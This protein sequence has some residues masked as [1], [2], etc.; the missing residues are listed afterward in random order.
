MDMN[1]EYKIPA[2]R[3]TVWKALNDPEV[4][5]Q[6]IPGCDELTKLG[7]DELEA[8]VTSKIGPVKAKFA[9]RVR[10]ENINAPVSYTIVGEGKG[11]AAGFAK[12]GADVSLEEIPDGTLLRYTA[13]AEVGGKLAQIGSRLIAGAS[14][15]MAD[16]FFGKFSEIVAT[17][18]PA[19]EPAAAA[20][21]SAAPPPSAI[22]I[23]PQVD[24]GI[25]PAAADFQGGVLRCQCERDPVVVSIGAQTAFN[26][27]CGCSKCWKPEG[28]LFSQIAVVG[29]DNLAVNAG[30]H[31]LA[32]VDP[33][34]AI[35]RHAC[36]D[37]GVHMYGRIENRDHPFHGFDF[38]HTELSDQSGWSPAEFA[39][40]VSSI[41]ETGTDPGE[42]D[43]I[44][45]RLVEL[46]LEPYDCLAPGLMDAIAAHTAKQ[47]G[48]VAV[49]PPR[50]ADG[51]IAI[52]PEVDG[53]IAAT[54]P[55]LTGGTLVCKCT[56]RP[57][58]VTISAQTAFNHVCGCSKCWKPDGALFSQVAVVGRD[59]LHVTANADK[60]A[61]VDS[62]AAIQRHACGDCGAH[63]YGRIENQDHPFH[64]FDFV[65]TELGRE[66]GWAAPEFAAFVSSIIETGT[67]PEAMDEV[68]GRRNE[69]GLKPHDVLTPQLMDLIA[70]H[71]AKRAAAAKSAPAP[72]PVAAAA[73]V[74]PPPS[75]IKIHPQVDHGI[76]PAVDDFS[77]G[78]LRCQC[79]SDPVVVSVGAQSA[80]NH[81][82][83]CSK[84]WKP[85]GALFSQIAVVGREH[86]TVT[87][88]E[89]KLS[90]V[91]PK[92]AIQRHACRD[93]GVHMYGRIEN[94]GHPFYGF[95]FIHTELSD[96][97][98]WAPAEFAAFVSSII[99][100]GTDPS[101]L[102]G[103]RARLVEL[104]LEPYDCLAPGLMDAIA[105][106]TAKQVGVVAVDPPRTADGKV[107]IH[108]QVDNGIPAGDDNFAG[109]TLV[110]KCTDR[111]VEVAVDSQTAF[112]HVCGCS[113]CWKPADALFSQ[114]AVVA[115]DKLSVTG[116]ADKLSVVDRNA[117]IQRYAC[118][119]C[120]VHMY[121][122]IENAGH[123]FHGFDF[124]HTE[125][126]RERGWSAPEFAA[127][128]SSIIETGTKPEA[129]DEVRARLNEL[130][131]KPHDVLS[132][133]LMDL[134]AAHTANKAAEPAP[135]AAAQPAAAPEP[136]AAVVPDAAPV[137]DPAPTPRPAE[138]APPRPAPQPSPPP[139]APAKSS[140]LGLWI[141]IV[142]V[143]LI[144]LYFVWGG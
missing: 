72:E 9:G 132:P 56:D 128:V 124:V 88:G 41:I 91:D 93:C 33:S 70:T 119:D 5:K 22:K 108:P 19:A 99:E 55:N 26:H 29:R 36:R 77:G 24:N 115:R 84:C 13:K 68:R 64:G 63:M 80:F 39:A 62:A 46:G 18:P 130:G 11:G 85:D 51:K 65:H 25:A 60:L 52:H 61:V 10:L 89:G 129:M 94:D 8:K 106:H 139:E 134:I 1:G 87:A 112:N 73:P 111:P 7:D 12:G 40:F 58:E 27:V 76:T 43:A 120:G 86:V 16:D 121:G 37:C 6:A 15:K 131:L 32:V 118:G 69:L 75:G 2:S 34:A 81:V 21:P 82:C 50:T 113:K 92:A 53:G 100:T 117:A 31:K 74:P 103:I 144:I 123:P 59:K 133:Q 105:A 54:D 109:G 14:K 48:V 125:L 45:G 101:E 98:G 38:V 96:E 83:G 79:G 57:V 30:E 44:R 138:S 116:N 23:H 67:K 17:L 104:G 114:V 90:V 3:A 135:Q 110:C 28:A 4:L 47:A 71:T 107:A 49:D 142:V 127:F 126:G 122:R 35:Q 20:P 137:A 95:D 141:G 66:R 136:V 97:R 78:S 140:N 42:L 143:L 102:D